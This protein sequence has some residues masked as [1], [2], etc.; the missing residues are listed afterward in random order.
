MLNTIPASILQDAGLNEA[1]GVLPPNY[2]FEVH[3]SIWFIRRNGYRRVALQLPE[4]FQRYALVLRDILRRWGPLEEAPI[5]ADVTYGACCID[6]WTARQLE[7]EA[8]IHYGHSCLIPVTVTQLPIMY[9]FVEITIPMEHLARTV[10]ANFGQGDRLALMATVQYVSS[11]YQLRELVEGTEGGGGAGNKFSMPTSPPTLSKTTTTEMEGETGGRPAL[12]IPQIR[13]LSPGEVLG[14]TAPR[15]PSDTTALIFVADGRFHLE[16]A[17]LAN[18]QLP[19]YRY[20]PYE[21]C[22]LR[23]FYDHGAMRRER[24]RAIERARGATHWGLILGTLGR[25]GS[26]KVMEEVRQQL[27]AAGKRVTRLLMSEVRPD[28]LR[29]LPH[30]EAWVQTSCPR[31]SID[32]GYTFDVPVLTPYELNVLL[33]RAASLWKPNVRAKVGIET[34]TGANDEKRGPGQGEGKGKGEEEEEIEIGEKVL[35]TLGSGSEADGSV[36]DT[37]SNINLTAETAYPMDFYATGDAAHVS[38]PWTPGYHLRPP[39]APRK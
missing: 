26:V 7:C 34:A 12:F 30:I 39:R 15:L 35:S 32:W 8:L 23:E 9:V 31:L 21:Q 6:D 1:V 13:P 27:Q 2:N 28:T 11:L 38:G 33:G 14:C 3:K 5:L 18:P 25:Q 29:S 19:A 37:D 24:A 36:A 22:L 20:D 16:A 10:M 17:M 4:G